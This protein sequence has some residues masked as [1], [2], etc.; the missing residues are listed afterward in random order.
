MFQFFSSEKNCHV[1]VG[2]SSVDATKLFF[3][4]SPM[5]TQ[6]KLE[7]SSIDFVRDSLI[8]VS[9]A[10]SSPCEAPYFASISAVF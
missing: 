6:N 8:F 2:S 10:G 4:L 9:K 3:S 5:L 1:C 7:Y